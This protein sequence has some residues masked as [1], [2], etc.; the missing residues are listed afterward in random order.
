MYVFN[1]WT[2]VQKQSRMIWLYLFCVASR[3]V[4]IIMKIRP[5][6]THHRLI[7][8]YVINP[9]WEKIKYTNYPRLLCEIDFTPESKKIQNTKE[10]FTLITP[11]RKRLFW[12]QKTIYD[13]VCQW[14]NDFTCIFHY[15]LFLYSREMHSLHVQCLLCLICNHF[16]Q[17][18]FDLSQLCYIEIQ[19]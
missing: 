8:D 5:N 2:K 4:N 11:T 9:K 16:Y 15:Y 12:L 3:E 6:W 17:S 19:M 13:R 18:L 7:S 14:F 1:W 10:L